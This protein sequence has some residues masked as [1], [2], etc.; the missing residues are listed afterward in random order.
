MAKKK[1]KANKAGSPKPQ[2]Q[3][4]TPSASASMEGLLRKFTSGR[5]K[6]RNPLAIAQEIADLAWEA[7]RPQDQAEL[8][9]QALT[10]SPD[11]ADAYV[12]LANQAASRDQTR[13]LLEEAVAAGQRAIGPKTF[14]TATGHFWLD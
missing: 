1:K 12:I 5:G 2:R 10:V 4:F 7:Q 3:G 9:R 8:A 14:E 11:C 6:P 13:Q